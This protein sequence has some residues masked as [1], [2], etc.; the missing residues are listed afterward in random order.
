MSSLGPTRRDAPDPA[1]DREIRRGIAR[2][3]SGVGFD[4]SGPTTLSPVTF[5]RARFI[6]GAAA[7]LG[8]LALA[9]SRCDATNHSCVPEGDS[10]SGV[11]AK[12]VIVV[13]DDGFTPALVTAQDLSNVTLTLKN[14]GTRPHGFTVGCVPTPNDY[15]CPTQS[16]FADEATIAPIPPGGSAT[17][18]FATPSIED[19]YP[20]RSTADGDTQ[21][22]QFNVN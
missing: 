10:V 3:L 13:D 12:F 21:T 1:F 18:T 7:A 20:F 15:G 2:Y 22:G 9:L 11:D 6:L 19:V 5:S 14:Q 4:P 17:A 16:C 8:S